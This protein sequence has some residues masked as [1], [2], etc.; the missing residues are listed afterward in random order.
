MNTSQIVAAT[1]LVIGIG[2]LGALWAFQTYGIYRF[3]GTAY[4]PGD[5]GLTEAQVMTFRSEDGF[6]ARAWVIAPKPGRPVLI[7]FYGNFAGIGPAMR[8]MAP[9]ADAGYGLVMMEYRGSG[10]AGGTPSEATFARDARA[11][12]DQLDAL[13]GTT[14]TPETRVI[15][16]FSLGSGVAARLASERPSGAVILEAA[17]GSLCDYFERR[18]HGAPFCRVMWAERYDTRDLLPAIAAP[19][20]FIH[21]ALDSEVPIGGAEEL[22]AAATGPKSFV[23]LEN[24]NHADLASHG[25]I[26]AIIAFL[27]GSGLG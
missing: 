21:G 6:V 13:L 9:L 27:Q 19:K 22:H 26:P 1:L 7:S 4:A 23:R 18:Y 2:M 16:G 5:V 24:G 14:V 8:R 12:Y 3:D 17:F 10:D 11:L 20:L 15:H 25:L